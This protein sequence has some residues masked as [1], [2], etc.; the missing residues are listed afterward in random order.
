MGAVCGWIILISF[1]GV[2]LECL[3]RLDF[4]ATNNVAEYKALILGL[5]LAKQ[6]KISHIT[7]YSDSQL[8]VSQ[9]NKEYTTKDART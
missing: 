6:L 4:L 9:T 8:I 7:M 1:D 3:V 2:D 5:E